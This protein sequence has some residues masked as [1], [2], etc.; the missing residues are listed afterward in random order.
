VFFNHEVPE[1]TRQIDSQ[2]RR[3]VKTK[4]NGFESVKMDTEF[5]VEKTQRMQRSTTAQKPLAT[6]ERKWSTVG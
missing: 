1:D 6:S 4:S 5:I 3:G 2:S